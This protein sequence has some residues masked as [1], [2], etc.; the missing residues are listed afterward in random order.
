[1]RRIYLLLG[2]VSMLMLRLSAQPGQLTMQ[3]FATGFNEPLF[4]THAGDDRIFVVEK[5]GKIYILNQQGQRIATPYLNIDPRV[6]STASERGLL[7]LAFHPDYKQNGYFFVNYTNSSGSTVVSR[8]SVTADSNVADPNSEE[9]LLTISQ[10]Y[11]NH[12]GGCIKFGPDGYLYIGMGDG[13]SGG[14]PGNRSQ[15]P[16]EL[17]GKMLR[18]DVDNGLPYTIPITNPYYGSSSTRNEIWAFGVRNPWRFSFDKLTGD[19]WIGDVGQDAQEEIDFWPAT[20]TTFPNFGWRCYEASLPYNTSGC[21]PQ[22]NYDFP[23]YY[24]NQSQGNCSVTGGY[25]YRGARYQSMWE[26]Y[27]HTDYCGGF[28]WWTHPDT[29]GGWT[30]TR[31]Q[32]PYSTYNLV[33]FGEDSYGEIYLAGI[34]T[35]IIYHLQDT[36]CTPNA[37]IPGGD[38]VYVC[39]PGGTLTAYGGPT[40]GYQWQLGGSD[41][42]G[43]TAASVQTAVAGDYRVIVSN[44]SCVDTSNTV[45]VELANAPTVSFS[46]PDTSYCDDAIPV[47]ATLS[48]MGGTIYGPGAS[49]IFFDPSTAGV[50]TH[51]LVYVYTD[52]L[53]GCSASD[54]FVVSVTVCV[55]RPEPVFGQLS[56]LPS[57]NAG[58]MTLSFR[59]AAAADY[60]LEVFDLQGRR[61]HGLQLTAGA[62]A[63]T[64]MLDFQDL[65]PGTYLLRLRIDDALAAAKFTIQ[66]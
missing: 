25:V 28:L 18:I 9:I 37:F 40:L 11:S 59:L 48:P 32:S 13:G 60:E 63:V 58:L 7:G 12:N 24:F 19:M 36:T 39:Q 10:P 2:M 49:G 52:P 16:N 42:S 1:M 61:L 20:A 22:G 34:T 62:G 46:L 4:V 53:S 33:S 17:L 6:N 54:T 23:I 51:Q 35:G 41:I 57:P 26:Y 14:D 21:Q 27:F 30:T 3:N 65:A 29:L 55:G 38:T 66:K 5:A 50:G 64:R 8:F 31:S 43:A 45:H 44:G 15:N 47:A 56:L